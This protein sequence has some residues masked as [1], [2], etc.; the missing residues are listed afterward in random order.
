M[1]PQPTPA[2]REWFYKSKHDKPTAWCIADEQ[3][4]LLARI[5]AERDALL[6]RER[7]AMDAERNAREQA[8]RERAHARRRAHYAL[9]ARPKEDED[10]SEEDT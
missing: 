7:A 9:R 3:D 10:S 8:A 6:A 4:A 2:V 1:G 5:K